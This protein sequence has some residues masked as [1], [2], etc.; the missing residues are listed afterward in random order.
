MRHKKRRRE[1]NHDE[2]QKSFQIWIGMQQDEK[3]IG[4]HECQAHQETEAHFFLTNAALVN[5]ET[6]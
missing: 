4:H 2:R 5:L 3:R 1:Q 6:S